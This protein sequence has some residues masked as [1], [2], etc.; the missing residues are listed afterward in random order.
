MFLQVAHHL[1]VY[2]E[3]W[4]EAGHP[5][6]ADALLRIPVYVAETADQAFSEPK[7]STMRSYRRMAKTLSAWS[8]AEAGATASEERIERGQRLTAISYEELLRDRLAYGTP[9]MVAERL[10]SA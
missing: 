2:R 4:R 3:A 1:G 9:D 10:S 5:N 6:D 8:A 7:A